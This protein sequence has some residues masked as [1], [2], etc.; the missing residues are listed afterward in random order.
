MIRWLHSFWWSILWPSFLRSEIRLWTMQN[1]PSGFPAA[2]SSGMDIHFPARDL[3]RARMRSHC[4]A[5]DLRDLNSA[6]IT[7]PSK[8]PLRQSTRRL[9]QKWWLGMGL[10]SF[11]QSFQLFG[12]FCQVAFSGI[13]LN[14]KIFAARCITHK[15]LDDASLRAALKHLGDIAVHLEW[16]D[17]SGFLFDCCQVFAWRCVNH[18][19]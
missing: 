12:S 3:S 6:W 19:A 13:S 15:R 11:Q 17:G 1:R 2:A 14:R 5:P 16:N 4:D 10:G 8:S 9:G 18:Y 7:S